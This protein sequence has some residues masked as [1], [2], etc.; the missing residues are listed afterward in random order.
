MENL[1]TETQ[2]TDRGSKTT[3][4][5]V[6]HK[7]VDENGDPRVTQHKE[8]QR[9]ANNADGDVSYDANK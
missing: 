9:S 7:S 3:S 5:T 2:G 4:K 1:S 6:K 8:I